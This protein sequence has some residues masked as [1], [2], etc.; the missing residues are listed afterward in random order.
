[1]YVPVAA[2]PNPHRFASIIARSRGET[3]A[4]IAQLRE[5]VRRIDP[6]LPGYAIR[7]FD[8]LLA[9]SRFPQRLLGTILLVLAGL[10]L[11]LATI[12]LFALTANSVAER[13]QEIGVR[14]AL[15]A[16]TRAVVWLFVR[17]AIVL[18]SA[19]LSI[20]L[21]GAAY[22][23][24]FVGTLFGRTDHAGIEVLAA[25]GAFLVAVGLGASLLP[26]RRAARIDPLVALRY[27]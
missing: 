10:A 27:D 21:V 26:A 9:G 2:E 3:S 23:G 12:G 15:G 13:T 4:A 24:R 11:V 19:G 14:L 17:R 22:S 25:V 5:E 1:V 20:G 7:T 6:D 8:E 16:E 18:L